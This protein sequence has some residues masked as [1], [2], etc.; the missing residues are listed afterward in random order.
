M[1]EPTCPV[2]G[3]LMDWEV[4]DTA[5]WSCPFCGEDLDS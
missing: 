1:S 2:C 4:D 3:P 5:V